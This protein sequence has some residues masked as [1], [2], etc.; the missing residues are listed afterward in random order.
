M[1]DRDG[2]PETAF[3]ACLAGRWATHVGRRSRRG[4]AQAMTEGEWVGQKVRIGPEAEL[5]PS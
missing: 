5:T 1:H 2:K 3:A 4:I